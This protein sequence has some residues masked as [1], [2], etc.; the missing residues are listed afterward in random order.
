MKNVYLAQPNYLYGNNA[1]LPYSAGAIAAYAF[2][3]PQVAAH[4]ALPPILFLRRDIAKVVEELDNPCVFGFS[5]YVWNFEY[6]LLL[7]RAVKAAYPDCLILFGGHH[8][9][10]NSVELLKDHR[11]IDILIYDEGEKPFRDILKAL[12]NGQGF[13]DITN[14]AYRKDGLIVANQLERWEDTDYPSPYLTGVF[15]NIISDTNVHFTATLETNRGC[16]FSCAYCDWGIY[17]SK[18]RA[19]P[20][21][22]IAE[23]IQWFSKNRIELVMGA[24]SNFGI[25]E[26]DVDI[27]KMLIKAKKETGYPQKFRVSYTK[28]SNKTV[29]AI[30]EAL[31]N[32]GMSKGATLSFQSLSERVLQNINRKNMDMGMFSELLKLYN[33]NN[34]PTYS[35]IIMG[36]PGETY[37]SFVQG[38]DTLL[39]NGQHNSINIY[40][41]ELLPNSLMASKEYMQTH[42]IQTIRTPLNQYHCEPQSGDITEYSNVVVSNST[43]T[44]DD[45]VLCNVFSVVVQCF[46]CLGLLQYI[47]V[48]ARHR[49]GVPYHKFYSQLLSFLPGCTGIGLIFNKIVNQIKG[50][51]S[52]S[53]WEYTNPKFGN[54]TWPLDEGAFLECMCLMDS[55]Y[56]ELTPFFETMIP[57]REELQELIRYQKAL[58]KKPFDRDFRL[59]CVYDFK[60]Y[61]EKVYLGSEVELQKKLCTYEVCVGKTYHSFA[62]YAVEVVWYG[63]KGGTN[64]YQTNYLHEGLA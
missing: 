27:A 55:F 5:N 30:N 1:Y 46:H 49:Y 32:S 38:I 51:S 17:K 28:N 59:T 20:M 26:R 45:W 61:F 39:E 23:E 22:R 12:L 42:A 9:Q 63:R 34:I 40:N 50:I 8:I 25:L 16:P 48:F 35:E 19:F 36:L 14:I 64:I 7:A 37:A 15:D 33:A 53:T 31:N 52:G 4:Y 44:M 24:D 3:D 54:I 56:E 60:D 18:L 62:L 47:A 11:F 43:M 41:C 10:T 58:V 57:N 21:E 29:Y 6:N 13:E 2:D